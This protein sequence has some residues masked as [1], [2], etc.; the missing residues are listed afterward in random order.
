MIDYNRGGDYYYTYA[1][2]IKTGTT[3][4]A[5]R[6]LITAGIAD[7]YAY[8][9]ICMGAPY[10]NSDHNGAMTDAK[11]LLKW[12]LT[13]LKLASPVTVETPCDEI[14]VEFCD[15]KDTLLVYPSEDVNTILP[16][17]YKEEDV[18]WK[19]DVPELVEAPIEKGEVLGKMSVYYKD[20]LIKEVDLV[21]TEE[22]KKNEISYTVHVFKTVTLSWQF[23]TAI[24][25]S[26]ALLIVYLVLIAHIRNKN[27]NRRVKKY[28]RM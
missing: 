2:G 20:Q 23:W 18:V 12:A 9:C 27:K 3:D 1:K 25:I 22:L 26:A 10:E 21:S 24:G 6:C 4:E 19:C 28:R 7:G 14:K 5:G 16:E 17:G 11:G 13:T 15:D 8:L